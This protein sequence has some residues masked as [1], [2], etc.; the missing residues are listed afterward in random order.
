MQCITVLAKAADICLI[1]KPY[2]GIILISL[3]C[4]GGFG[5]RAAVEEDDL[6]DQYITG[7]NNN[8]VVR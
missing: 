3:I 6:L 4:G 2:L 8:A 5:S 7:L 1:L